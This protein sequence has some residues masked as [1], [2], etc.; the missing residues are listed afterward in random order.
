MSKKGLLRGLTSVMA[1]IT[2]LAI[3]G[4]A[5]A[6]TNAPVIN[7]YMHFATS[8]L[9]L[10]EGIEDRNHDGVVDENDVDKPQYFTSDFAKDVNNPTEED[11]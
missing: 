5:A 2:A 3:G 7:Q 11:L 4:S 6:L 9:V 8:K 10:K 1:M